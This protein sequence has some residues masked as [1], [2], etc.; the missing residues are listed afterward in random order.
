MNDVPTNFPRMGF[1][2][3]RKPYEERRQAFSNYREKRLWQRLK[4]CPSSLDVFTPDRII[5]RPQRDIDKLS[6]RHFPRSPR[7][8]QNFSMAPSERERNGPRAFHATLKRIVAD[9]E[10]RNRCAHRLFSPVIRSRSIV[11]AQIG[12]PYYSLLIVGVSTSD[13]SSVTCKSGKAL[14]YSVLFYSSF[15]RRPAFLV[16]FSSRY[17]ALGSAPTVSLRCERIDA[18]SEVTL[19]A[20]DKQAIFVRNANTSA[21]PSAVI[22]RRGMLLPVERMDG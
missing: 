2:I 16:L 8:M 7:R 10:S 22:G 15:V 14:L 18:L 21:P 6:P 11:R 1:A 17:E 12:M 19:C 4:L 13:L 9:W 20:R 3:P 5:R